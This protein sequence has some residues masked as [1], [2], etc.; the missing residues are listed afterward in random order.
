VSTPSPKQPAHVLPSWFE[1]MRRHVVLSLLI[2]AEFVV[3]AGLV[4]RLVVSDMNHPETWTWYEW[5]SAC[6]LAP[7]I[8]LAVS[9]VALALSQAS[10]DA[11][12]EG[13]PLRGLFTLSGLLTFGGIEVWASLVERSET[14]RP[15]AADT[16]LLGSLGIPV[17][18]LTPSVI[19]FAFLLPVAVVYVGF[20]NKPPTLED[21]TTWE[22]M[23]RRKVKEAQ[24]RAQARAAGAGGLGRA[25]AANLKAARQTLNPGQG[26][27][28]A[29]GINGT[30]SEGADTLSPANTDGD[31]Q[32]SGVLPAK[33]TRMPRNG[34]GLNWTAADLRGYCQETYGVSLGEA[35]AVG[36][37]KAMKK[38]RQ[39]EGVAGAPW[40]AH[41]ATV[42]AWADQRYGGESAQVARG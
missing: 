10:S 29:P 40:A 33:V 32:D 8:G 1:F 9:G 24:Y 39:L 6:V 13:K 12:G 30:L 18:V 36:Y 17:S 26:A 42:K 5:V 2:I 31:P 4:I 16:M 15:S 34:K 7:A 23:Q 28:N 21:E 25:I 35:E 3:N 37:I 41:R 14:V 38:S 20:T 11:F 19:V 22:E 27:G